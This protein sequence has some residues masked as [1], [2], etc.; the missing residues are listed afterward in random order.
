MP[1]WPAEADIDAAARVLDRTGRVHG[2]WPEKSPLYDEMNPIAKSEFGGLVEEMFLAAAGI[3]RTATLSEFLPDEII[4]FWRYAGPALW[5][6]SEPAF[7]IEIR[8]RYEQAHLAAS[9][10]VDEGWARRAEG[11]LAYLL[12]TDQFPRNIYRGSTHAFATDPLA[13]AM[14]DRAIAAGFDMATEPMLRMFFYLPFQHHEDAASQA[15]SVA[16]FTRHRDLTGDGEPLRYA[17]G[18]AAEIA[19][20]GR[21]PHRNAVLGRDSTEAECDYLAKGGS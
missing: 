9:M 15:R 11:A 18:H 5:F 12:L 19:R 16:L 7:D 4:A 13:R 2:W 6:A 14:A 21:F 10:G 17:Q 8:R 1:I 20:F 3:S